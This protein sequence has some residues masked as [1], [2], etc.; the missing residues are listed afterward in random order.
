VTQRKGRREK[1]RKQDNIEESNAQT[2]MLMLTLM[3]TDTAITG[4]KRKK[5]GK[6][7]R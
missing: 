7:T 6:R 3:L 1:E 2:P 5:K 4:G